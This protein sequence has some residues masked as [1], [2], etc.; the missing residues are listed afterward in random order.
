V[1]SL[2][3]K[4]A[5]IT[6]GARGIGLAI[7][8]RYIAAGARVVISDIAD[9]TEVAKEI[10][11]A[12]L[13]IDVTSEKRVAQAL[14]SAEDRIGKLDVLIN[15][16]GGALADATVENETNENYQKTL[17]INTDSVFFGLKH[18]SRHMNDGG[19]IVNTASLAAVYTVPEYASY[20]AAK[21]AV[22]ALTRSAAISLG[23]RGIRVNAVLPGTHATP[24]QPAEGLEA[25]LC[26]KLAPLAME[27]SV[28]D[29][30]GVYHFLAA[31]ES[32]YITGQAIV[33]DGG[34]GL[35]LTPT[36][37]KALTQDFE[38]KRHF[39]YTGDFT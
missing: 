27:G 11:A 14:H 20:N 15:N 35:G 8:Q 33:V 37:A 1:F 18:G 21:A 26:R 16:A 13:P 10:G 30:A 36:A 32:S 3:G 28:D 5:F 2:Q 24:S 31:R 39:G 29:L 25:H 4:N 23:P 38:G 17:R 12:Y 6:G 7:A 34:W 22:L 9:A 19:A